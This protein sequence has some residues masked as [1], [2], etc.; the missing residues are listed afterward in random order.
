MEVRTFFL[1]E[2]DQDMPVETKNAVFQEW[3]VSPRG[4]YTAQLNFDKAGAWGI[5][6]VVKGT[7]G[8][9]R[10][11]STSI[12]VKETTSTPAI[13]SPA[14]RS[15]SKT[16][17]DVDSLDLLTTDL[18]PDPEL[19]D[20]TIA[21]AIEENQPL[22]VVFST[23][24]YC[25][26]S[27]CGPQLDVVKDIKDVYKDRI[28]VIHIEVYDNPQDIQGDLS[29]AIISPTLEEWGLPTEPWTFIVDEGGL[30]QAKFEAFTTRQ[31][32]E[33]ALLNVLR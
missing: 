10:Q 26:T 3:P 20:K 7:D 31:E 8:V 25:Q 14:P 15:A 29:N 4:I 22:M 11:S 1:A 32:L 33:E 30:V 17:A 9:E 2:L 13:G 5:G 23:P 28:N 6:I 16:S 18:S 19:Y 24:A 12:Q 21:E 27:T